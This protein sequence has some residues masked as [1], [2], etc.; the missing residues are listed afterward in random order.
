MTS[1][2]QDSIHGAVVQGSTDPI[3]RHFHQILLWPLELVPG[4]TEDDGATSWE[5]LLQDGRGVWREVDDE[6][7]GD[8]ELF[9]D[10]HYSEFV[11]FLPYVQRFLYGEGAARTTGRG[12]S[13]IRVLRRTD[14][15]QVRLMY[16][17]DPDTLVLDV[18]HVDLYSFLD[19]EVIILVVEL[20]GGALSLARAQQ[21]LYRVG[22]AYPTHWGSDGHGGHCPTRAEWLAA[23]GQVLAVSDYEKR[24]K[25]LV[26]VG[27]HRAPAIAAHWEYLLTPMVSYHATQADPLRYRPIEYHRMPQMGY[28]AV[29]RLSA[30]TRADFVRLG[31]VMPPGPP[32]ALP[33]SERHAADFGARYCY[34]RYWDDGSAS[35]TRTM[36]SGE[37][38][39]IV[40]SAGDPYFVA[41]D[42]GLLGHFR[43][44]HFLLF[45]I[46]HFHK[47]ALV[48][49]SDRLVGALADLDVRETESV[50][51]FK[52]RIRQ[53]KEVFLRFTHRYWFNEVSD[54]AQAK[55]LYRMCRHALG[56]ERLYAE[57]RQE[58]H[59]M[60]EYLDSDSIRRQSN[61]VIRLTVVTTVGLI[62]TITT[63]YFGMNLLA[64]ADAHLVRKI[65]YFV[66]GTMAT[67]A[68]TGWTIMR[69]RRLS[70]FLE[71]L[72]D[73]QLS[74]RDKLAAFIGVWRRRGR[75]EE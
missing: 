12:K 56:L 26:H 57:V 42:T 27:R 63:G 14:V 48:L 39:T 32:G 3:V 59:D 9:E 69:S 5:R 21:T 35:G 40:G 46:P 22:R 41:R 43:H 72:S 50:K 37:A 20:A 16:P 45:L 65:V 8:P 17:D 51:R 73:E 55:E 47:A 15:R 71:A 61:M 75:V 2:S 19:I 53:Y 23:D 25:Y 6:F 33:V 7:P 62:G 29:E 36:C 58:I 49:L 30:L 10:R 1:P 31:L 68:L 11:T 54:Q 60:S 66:L 74:A 13:P 70:D 67:T 28:L 24:E 64:E 52:R 34:D 4:S 38:L 18:V 44:Q